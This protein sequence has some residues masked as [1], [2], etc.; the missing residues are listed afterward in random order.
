MNQRRCA[1]GRHTGKR[2]VSICCLKVILVQINW[3]CYTQTNVIPRL[4]LDDLTIWWTVSSFIA[5][6][7]ARKRQQSFHKTCK[8]FIKH[9]VCVRR[10]IYFFK[11]C[12][13]RSLHFMALSCAVYT[14]SN[15]CAA[16]KLDM[17]YHPGKFGQTGTKPQIVRL[18]SIHT[19]MWG[20]GVN[21]WKP[22]PKLQ[23]IGFVRN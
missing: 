5:N 8:Y 23:I 3:H 14:N 16:T 22:I 18:V 9:K 2:A 19:K 17:L 7:M 20:F 12:P 4:Y 15:V 1:E 21:V 11:P 13:C 10:K 6:F